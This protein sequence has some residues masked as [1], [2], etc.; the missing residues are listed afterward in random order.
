MDRRKAIAVISAAPIALVA[1]PAAA[2]DDWQ[3]ADRFHLGFGLGC[4]AQHGLD[5]GGRS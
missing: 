4:A 5:A 1:L 2:E 3:D